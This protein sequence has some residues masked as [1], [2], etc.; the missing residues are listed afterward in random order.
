MTLNQLLNNGPAFIFPRS[1]PGEVYLAAWCFL[2][3]KGLA[4]AVPGW[5][6]DP[7]MGVHC[8]ETGTE[9]TQDSPTWF[10][11]RDAE[12]MAPDRDI[13]A[14]EYERAMEW[15]RFRKRTPNGTDRDSAWES[16]QIRIEGTLYDAPLLI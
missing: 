11:N 14:F 4:W 13:S 12:L 2:T 15:E 10:T 9:F 3:D 8:L 6:A 5:F 16:V 7:S 1:K